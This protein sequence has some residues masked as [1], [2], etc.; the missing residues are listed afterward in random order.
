MRL[1]PFIFE[2][3]PFF[4]FLIGRLHGIILIF[5]IH[6]VQSVIIPPKFAI[7]L[8]FLSIFVEIF[9]FHFFNALHSAGSSDPIWS[10]ICSN[11]R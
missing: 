2:R 11:A 7:L 9:L 6:N 5:F 4:F 3:S 1:L 8:I 10:R